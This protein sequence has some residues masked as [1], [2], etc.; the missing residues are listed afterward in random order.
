[1]NKNI[2][3]HGP[4]YDVF[5]AIM[6]NKLTVVC[7]II[8]FAL[9]FIACTVDVFFDY[10]NDVIA[11]NP[12]EI[13]QRPSA[14]HWFGTDSHGRDYFARIMYATRISLVIAL[15]VTTAATVVST[16]IGGVAAYVGGWF[17]TLIMRL[18]DAIL[19]IP[20]TL[21][22]ICLVAVLSNSIPNIILA[23]TITSI[24]GL[25]RNARAAFMVS[26]QNEYVEAARACGTNNL[27]IIFGHLLP[28]S[29][30]PIIVTG[31]MN[32]GSVIIATASMGYL[33]LGIKPPAPE[34][35]RMLSESQE[36]MRTNLY[37]LLIPGLCIL[38][39]ATVFNLLGDGIRD[40]TDPRLR[41]YVK[42]KKTPFW[43]R[44]VK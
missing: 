20:G 40:A 21:L 31:T 27:K 39:T 33:G 6:R 32:I 38:I 44:S 34:W 35:G 41:G 26:M 30:G 19:A 13:R 37:L 23:L 29:L 8:A 28:N 10:D 2:R 4:G 42:P 25:L 24:P 9:I 12:M 14:E 1:M 3:P 15:S 18:T 5:R 11:Q 17:D 16:I 36:F 7:L 22:V 43:K